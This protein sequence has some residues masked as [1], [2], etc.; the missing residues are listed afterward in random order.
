MG[1][2]AKKRDGMGT[3]NANERMEL[4]KMGDKTIGFVQKTLEYSWENPELVPSFL[5][6]VDFE[7]DLRGFE[8]FRSLYQPV[9]QIADALSDT[10]LLT[11][12]EPYTAALIFY[13]AA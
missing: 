8:T 10:M 1:N 9:L 6:V 7:A 12:S 2:C 13:N 5:N 11:G 4:P 3:D